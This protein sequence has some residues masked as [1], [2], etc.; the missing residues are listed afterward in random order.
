M[1]PLNVGTH[2]T[3]YEYDG[4]DEFGTKLANGVYLYRM[5][6]KD[7]SGSDF[8]KLDTGTDQFFQHGFGKMVILR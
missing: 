3:E 6:V 4:T 5:V 8:K 2:I 1:G 7:D